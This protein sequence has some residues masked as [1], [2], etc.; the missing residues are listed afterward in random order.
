MLSRSSVRMPWI[1]SAMAR[2]S[3]RLL[4]LSV[5]VS[6]CGCGK[7]LKEGTVVPEPTTHHSCV[8]SGSRSTVD[9]MRAPLMGGL[10]YMGRTMILSCDRARCALSV[11]CATCPGG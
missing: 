8:S 9:T 11:S 4:L 5:W 10:E 2:Q 6:V 3:S 1:R 7:R